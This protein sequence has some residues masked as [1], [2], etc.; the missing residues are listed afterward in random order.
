MSFVRCASDG[1]EDQVSKLLE[2]RRPFERYQVYEGPIEVTIRYVVVAV[3]GAGRLTKARLQIQHDHLNK[4]YSNLHDKSG[5]PNTARYP[6]TQHMSD[7]PNV[8]F[9]P[10][11]LTDSDV[12]YIDDANFPFTSCAS[13]RSYCHSRLDDPSPAHTLTI[14][15]TTLVDRTN[16]LRI[17]LGDAETIPSAFAAI[18]HG[19]VGAPESLGELSEYSAG[20]TLCHEI[21]HCFGCFHPFSNET[22]CSGAMTVL[23]EQIHTNEHY[24]RQ[25]HPNTITDLARAATENNGLDNSGRD[26]L[27]CVE[28]DTTAVRNHDGHNC[29]SGR[30]SCY[31][32]AELSDAKTQFEP[33]MSIMDY[34]PDRVMLGFSN[35]NVNTMRFVVKSNLFTVG[36]HDLLQ[37]ENI[38][39]PNQPTSSTPASTNDGDPQRIWKPCLLAGGSAAGLFFLALGLDNL[40]SGGRFKR[41]HQ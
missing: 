19:T 22:D 26:L 16:Q 34:G 1:T 4:V 11:T 28:K 32:D 30:Y 29:S 35:S 40:T 31:T 27:I 10:T 23:L 33:F 3:S 24:P 5:I 17:V 37:P 13:V 15:I 25:R 18:H 21:G 39:G 12:L 8:K 2:A 7:N 36:G 41:T 6:Y 9:L 38:T 20:M 14:F